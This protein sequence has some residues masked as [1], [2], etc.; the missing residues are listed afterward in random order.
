M[1]RVDDKA[2]DFFEPT[3]PLLI[4]R[5]PGRIDLMGGIGDYSGVRVAAFMG[6]GIIADVLGLGAQS[7]APGR[8]N[9]DDPRFGGYLA[10]AGRC[11]PEGGDGS[12]DASLEGHGSSWNP[13]SLSPGPT[14]R[15]PS[16]ASRPPIGT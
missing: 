9:I 5:A 1:W 3:R 15:L 4:A 7:V 11:R 14:R 10:N 2:G 13:R 16:R 8:V 6:Y 12:G